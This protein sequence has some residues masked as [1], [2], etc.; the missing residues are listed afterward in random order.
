MNNKTTRRLI[1]TVLAMLFSVSL[2]FPVQVQAVSDVA[3]VSGSSATSSAFQRKTFYAQERFWVFYAS[4]GN[5]LY[6]SSVDG[7]TWDSPTTVVSQGYAVDFSVWFDGTAVHYVCGSEPDNTYLR[8]RKGTPA[9]NGVITWTT[10]EQTIVNESTD[11]E[12]PYI[13]V[14]SDGYPFV[15]QWWY[16]PSNW[17]CRVWKSSTN[18]GTWTTAAGFPYNLTSPSNNATWGSIIPLTGGKMYAVYPTTGWRIRGRLYNGSGWEAEE[19]VGTS[20]IEE[21]YTHSVV[22]EGDD[23]HFVFLKDSTYDMVYVKRTYGVGWGSEVTLDSAESSTSYPALTID[24]SDLYVFWQNSNAMYYQRYVDADGAWES[25]QTWFTNSIYGSSVISFYQVRNDKLGV[26]WTTTSSYTVRFEFFNIYRYTLH[27]LY[28]EDSGLLKDANERAVNVTVNFIGDTTFTFE[29]NGTYPRSFV[30]IPT[31]FEFDLSNNREYWVSPTENTATIYVFEAS[32]TV[33]TISFLD[34]AGALDDY[35]FVEAQRYI[36]GSLMT[37][38]KRKADLEDKVT[39][40]LKNGQKYN[41]IIKDGSTYTFGDLLITSDTTVQLTLKGIEFPSNIVLG[42]KYVRMWINR[43]SNLTSVS[44]LYQDTLTLTTSVSLYVYFMNSTLAYNAT[45]TAQTFN[46]TWASA[47]YNVSY[48]ARMVTSHTQFGNLE[49]RATLPRGFSASP[50]GLDFL[51]SLDIAT[52]QLI[53]AFLILASFAVF[54]R[55]SVPVGAFIGVGVAILLTWIGWI[56][57]PAP[58]LVTALALAILLGYAY[59]RRRVT[60]Y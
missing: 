25:T 31:Y 6:T 26:A 32:T 47:N 20:D 15:M 50:W 3:S 59:A 5:M 27:G 40:A 54:S 35:P 53:P 17:L 8:Y 29:L 56:N 16:Y 28:D 4:D 23:V 9:T 58:A 48:Y 1:F 60:V 33:Y 44:F 12:F 19:Y 41:L 2:F 49:W 14:D 13:S 21:A 39:M 10:S 51:G 38:E 57:I 55:L 22:S 42:Y 46:H 37:V 24:G 34:L 36:N 11:Q 7:L 43:H 30:T 18:N 45:E 52:S